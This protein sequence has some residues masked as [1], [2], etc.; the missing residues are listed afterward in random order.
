MLL[1]VPIALRQSVRSPGLVLL[2]DLGVVRRGLDS[3]VT[4]LVLTDIQVGA[5]GPMEM[6]GVVRIQP[7]RPP[8]GL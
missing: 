7:P 8:C 3:G 6:S 1:G 5:L 2:G 4:E